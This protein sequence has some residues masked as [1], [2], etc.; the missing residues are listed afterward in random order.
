MLGIFR[1]D[2]TNIFNL[3]IAFYI[4]VVPSQTGVDIAYLVI[5]KGETY[6]FGHSFSGV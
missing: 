5:E 1:E 6:S 3:C 2:E 4:R